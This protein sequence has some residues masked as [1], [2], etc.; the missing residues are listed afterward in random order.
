MSW[1]VVGR[2]TSKGPGKR[3]KKLHRWLVFPPCQNPVHAHRRIVLTH[4]DPGLAP[5]LSLYVFAYEVCEV[6][7]CVCYRTTTFF[8][9]HVIRVVRDKKVYRSMV[10]GGAANP[11]ALVHF[12]T[13][14][15]T[16]HQHPSPEYS[17][18]THKT[19]TELGQLYTHPRKGRV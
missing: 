11:P 12:T 1:L 14:T 6:Y 8:S 5:R 15:T 2:S 10:T 3:K 18:K 17:H 16:Y 13:P 4:V 9:P 7:V 19:H